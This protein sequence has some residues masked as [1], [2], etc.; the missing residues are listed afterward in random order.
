M[1]NTFDFL[2]CSADKLDL[3]DNKYDVLPVKNRSRRIEANR[4]CLAQTLN[5]AEARKRR[6]SNLKNLEKML[7]E[8]RN[9]AVKTLKIKD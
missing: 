5:L 3:F 9:W 2:N 7:V 4:F 1:T 6:L 8:S